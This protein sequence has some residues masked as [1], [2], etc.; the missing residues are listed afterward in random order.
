MTLLLETVQSFA[1]HVPSVA[2]T[3]V[4]DSDGVNVKLH[5]RA[6]PTEKLG[7]I[8]SFT[9]WVPSTASVLNE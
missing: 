3:Y 2:Y 5:G 8:V 1:F 6:M 7:P 4:K 9:D